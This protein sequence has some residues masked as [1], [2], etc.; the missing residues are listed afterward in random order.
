MKGEGG[1]GGGCALFGGSFQG[2]SGI[3]VSIK[4]LIF[5]VLNRKNS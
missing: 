1:G 5:E 3:V 4:L 2:H